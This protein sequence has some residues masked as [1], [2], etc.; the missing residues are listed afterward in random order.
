LLVKACREIG[1]VRGQVNN[2]L[3]MRREIYHHDIGTC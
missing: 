2:E 3:L 1:D